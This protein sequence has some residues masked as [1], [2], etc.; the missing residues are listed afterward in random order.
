MGIVIPAFDQGFGQQVSS[1]SQVP[2]QQF[3]TSTDNFGGV[4]AKRTAEAGAALLKVAQTV[5]D[6]SLQSDKL[7]AS[8]ALSKAK[9]LANNRLLENLYSKKPEDLFSQGQTPGEIYK[10]STS[11]FDD[12]SEVQSMLANNRQRKLFGTAYSEFRAGQSGS[13]SRHLATQFA[14]YG[15]IVHDEQI[16]ESDKMIE[17]ASVAVENNPFSWQVEADKVGADLASRL[18][19]GS[20]TEEDVSDQL[21]KL[22]TA[23]SIGRVRGWFGIASKTN[24]VQAANRLASGKLDQSQDGKPGEIQ[25]VWNSLSPK[26]RKKVRSDLISTAGSTARLQNDIEEAADS[27]IEAKHQRMTTMIFALDGSKPVE[28]QRM[29]D[30]FGQIEQSPYIKDTVKDNI[31]DL[32]SSG[33]IDRDDEPT[34]LQL[35]DRIIAG[36]ITTLDE[37]IEFADGKITFETLGGEIISLIKQSSDE[38]FTH[39][40]QIGRS[41]LGMTEGVINVD[42]LIALRTSQFEGLFRDWYANDRGTDGDPHKGSINAA[43]KAMIEES[44]DAYP[45]DV[46]TAQ[47]LKMIVK[48]AIDAA[49]EGG[50]ESVAQM[51]KHKATFTLLL[52]FAAPD[53]DADKV[54]ADM[55]KEGSSEGLST[56]GGQ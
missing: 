8:K 12:V 54:W 18:D 42:E 16:E 2:L 36:E 21:H 45:F 43:M 32:I 39:H 23:I 30:L 22:N 25:N 17:A 56:G 51:A 52:Q 7:A 49:I 24:V 26:E 15:K 53:M 20:I 37:A 34:V 35:K 19:L 27:R 28:R 41:Q 31:R 10:S 50:E 40:L 38:S 55:Y 1:G 47:R 6:L 44:R 11:L 46:G 9:E 33:G 5:D 48:K 29:V 14:Q 4:E 13:I 3:D